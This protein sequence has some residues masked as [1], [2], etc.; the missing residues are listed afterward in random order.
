MIITQIPPVGV[1]RKGWMYME[2]KFNVTGMT[3]SACSAHVE[4][5]VKKLKGVQS[6]NVNLLQNRMTVSFDDESLSETEIISA[7][8]EG[9]YGASVIG[10]E[11][12]AQIQG[13]NIAQ[14]EM[15]SMVRRLWISFIFLVPLMYITMGHMV[16]LPLPSFLS[17]ME[18][19][20]S[21]ALTQM[22]LVLP[23]MYVNRKFFD[24]GFRTLLKGTPNMDSLIAVGASASF[25]YGVFA[26]YRMG[27][28]LGV[29]NMALVK[30]YHMDLYFESVS[31]ILTLI[32]VG[33]YM[34]TRSKGKT[35]EAISKLLDLSPK[36]ALVE[37]DG[38]QI[39]IG[40]EEIL[41]GD[42]VIVKQGGGVPVDGTVIEGRASVDESA[43]TG[44]S[45]PIEKSPGDKVISA[46]INKAGFIKFR[47]ERVG[48]DTTLSQ[49][50][51][52]VEDASGS[53]APIAKL[54]DKISGVFVPI[55]MGIS[56]ITVVVWL[57]L[58][59]SFEFALSCGI[60]VLVISCPCALGLA[61]PTAIMVGTGKGAENG[62]LIRSAESLETAH[63]IDT[64]VL[65][66][67]GTVTEGHPSVTDILCVEGIKEEELLTLAA[68]VEKLSEHPLAEAILERAKK[69]GMVLKKAEQ[70]EAIAGQGIRATVEEKEILAGNKKM[71]QENQI[72]FSGFDGQ[73]FAEQGKTPL[74]F[75]IDKKFAGVIAASDPMKESSKKAVA[76][77]EKMGI[78][79]ILLTGD[80][81]KTAEAIGHQAGIKK[82]IAEVLP[83]DKE[84][85]IRRLQDNGKKVAMIGDGIN[86]APALSRADVGIAIGAGT[87]VAI[88]SADIVLM[89]SDLLD[90]VSA[91][92]LSKSVIK[93]IKENLFWAF[94]YNCIGIPL[95][96]GIWYP[97]FAIKL[98]PMFGAAAMSLS[99]VCVVSN[100]LRL[101][102]FKPS[103]AARENGKEI[104]SV[105]TSVEEKDLKPV[106]DKLN[107]KCKGEKTMN[108]VIMIE[109][110][111]CAHCTGR[112]E[113]A[114]NEM[115]GVKAEVSLEE[116]CA[117]VTLTKEVADDELKKAVEDAGYQVLS[118]Q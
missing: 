55:V 4:K 33:K 47:A 72:S 97:A 39:E 59:Q 89:K 91:I 81:K 2:Q 34:E 18:N 38:V 30:Q 46:S 27:Y 86:D 106:N 3:C 76:E 85:E 43:L 23:V 54:A 14:D 117:K 92:Q 80:N 57:I 84:K 75:A 95:A 67:T 79:V 82:V 111:M 69:D 22:L 101:K 1:Y 37:R 90:S 87:D 88:E 13:K 104:T 41:P 62:I 73:N 44:E 40:A 109:G 63:S 108:K 112:V 45:I 25:I 70:F 11:K 105:S 31:M 64:V 98:S 51:Q 19:A 53:K 36:T 66:K 74:Y 16:G 56:F 107:D 61:T 58:G 110:M 68:S 100:A 93:N 94:F 99:S 12:K 26:I 6:V 29:Q 21:Y 48:K 10:E 102:F 7:V 15:K 35:S 9:G 50:I 71:M 20:V 96:A 17:G 77:F 103:F 118:I 83:Q 60:A 113:K 115:D 42:I 28:G 24:V 65:D 5:S 78:D 32:T 49:I 114:L 8:E 116:K 52:L